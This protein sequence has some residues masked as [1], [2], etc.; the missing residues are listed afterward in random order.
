[1]SYADLDLSRKRLDVHLLEESGAT[2][3]ATAISPDGDA[4]RTL[5][6]ATARHGEPARA[7]RWLS[8]LPWRDVEG[9]PRIRWPLGSRTTFGP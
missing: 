3:A 4:L 7:P 5:V 6:S 8:R 1:M 9:P 2:R